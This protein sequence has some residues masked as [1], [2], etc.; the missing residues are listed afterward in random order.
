MPIECMY[1]LN[2]DYKKI[3]LQ[4]LS[5]LGE[6]ISYSAGSLIDY[7]F[8]MKDFCYLV[9]DGAIKQYFIDSE[10]KERI[11]FILSRGDL[12]G[13]I[14]ML[15]KTTDMVITESMTNCIVR[16]I[17]KTEYWKATDTYP[18]LT[19]ALL[20]LGSTKF[21]LLLFLLYDQ[22]YHKV[23]LQLR[24]LLCRLAVQHGVPTDSGLLINL[25]LT[26]QD[27]AD[28]LNSGRST[29]TRTLKKLRNAGIIEVRSRK[30]FIPHKEIVQHTFDVSH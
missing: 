29:V 11:L 28:M 18:A 27:L 10:G 16:K 20:A 30:F 21:R 1:R 26:H 9:L 13:D 14:T 6:E 4:Y 25:I 12:F 15:Q 8:G 17:R 23:E 22:S 19:K 5:S 2:L 24:H 7:D 3:I